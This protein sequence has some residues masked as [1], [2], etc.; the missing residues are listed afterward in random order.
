MPTFSSECV[1]ICLLITSSKSLSLNCAH[2]HS[3]NLTFLHQF[4][5]KNLSFPLY[6]FGTRRQNLSTNTLTRTTTTTTS[7]SSCRYSTISFGILRIARKRARKRFSSRSERNADA[8]RFFKETTTR[9][10]PPPPRHRY[11]KV[12]WLKLYNFYRAL[13]SPVFR[14]SNN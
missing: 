6:T 5:K 9:I 3:L 11:S 8:A 2:S 10:S 7:L 4:S 13:A 14:V 1:C 12:C